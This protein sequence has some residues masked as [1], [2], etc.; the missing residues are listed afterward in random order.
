MLAL[1]ATACLDSSAKPRP[2]SKKHSTTKAVTPPAGTYAATCAQVGSEELSSDF[3]D[4]GV[5]VRSGAVVFYRAVA[6]AGS[7]SDYRAVAPNRYTPA[8]TLVLVRKSHAAL[9]EVAPSQ[10]H[11][12]SLVFDPAKLTAG[13]SRP[14]SA[15][16]PALLLPSC[17]GTSTFPWLQYPGAMIVAGPRCAR[18]LVTQLRPGTR[19]A[20]GKPAKVKI[21]FGRRMC[22]KQS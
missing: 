9:V 22:E 10:R 21:P 16:A 11:S 6:N 1:L 14:V 8:Q 20:I 18:L 4:P 13:E 15:G 19:E 17:P 12:V 7:P 3:L 2:K 5:S